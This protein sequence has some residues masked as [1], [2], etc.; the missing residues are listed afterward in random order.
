MRKFSGLRIFCF[1]PKPNP[2]LETNKLFIPIVAS[3]CQLR[4]TCLAVAVVKIVSDLKLSCREHV[5]AYNLTVNASVTVVLDYDCGT[6]I[7]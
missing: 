6:D 4:F 1:K 2:I 3:E 5:L 7:L